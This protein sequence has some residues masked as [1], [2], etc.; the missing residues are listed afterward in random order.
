MAGS[1][2]EFKLFTANANPALAEE[3]A[4]YL[5]VRLG[6]AKVARFSDGEICISIEEVCEGRIFCHSTY[7]PSGER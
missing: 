4:E 1:R 2:Q 6:A 7:L 3:I 5:G